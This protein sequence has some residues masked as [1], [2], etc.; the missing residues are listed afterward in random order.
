MTVNFTVTNGTTPVTTVASV[1]AG[2]F[3]L[4]PA[5]AAYS[6]NQWVPYAWRTETVVG[7]ADPRAIPSR[8][9]PAT[10]SIRA[11][12][13]AAARRGNGTLVNLGDGTYTYTFKKNLSP[14]T[15]PDGTT[16]IGYDRTLTH[17]VSI[18]TGGHNGPT[19]EGDFDFVPERRRR[20]RDPQHRP[21]RDLQEVPRP[22]VRR[23]RRRPRHGRGLRHL[24]QPGQLR[25]PERRERRDGGH[26]PQDPRRLGTGTRTPVPTAVLRQPEHRR[27]TKAPTTART[28]SGATAPTPFPGKGAEFPAVLANCQACHT[29]TGADVDN[30]KNVPSRAACGS[31]H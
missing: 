21:D 8:S 5:A 7:T 16:L 25:R 20:D 18:Y 11:T 31:C 12:A 15:L 24:P 1:S 3:K 6:Y 22:G 13:R 26:D 9:R 2:I 23:P 10:R 19:G 30:W 17:R 14:A 27:R 28:S 4:V 29:G